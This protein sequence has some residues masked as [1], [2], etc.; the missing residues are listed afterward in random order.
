M[1]I[2]AISC[3]GILCQIIDDIFMRDM[4]ENKYLKQSL[5]ESLV[6]LDN[7]R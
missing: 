2:D 5:C 1:N 3:Q 6:N 4:T 7:S